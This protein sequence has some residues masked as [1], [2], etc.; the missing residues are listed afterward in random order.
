AV[1]TGASNDI[2][3]VTEIARNMVTKWGLS[4]R[5]GPISYD[6]EDNEPFLG[7]SMT[8]SGGIS[9]ETAHAIDEEMRSIIDACYERS[10]N[11]L[12]DNMAK[13]HL[14][15]DALMKY[16]T[17]DRKQIDEIMAGHEPGPPQSW[18]DDSDSSGSGGGTAADVGSKTTSDSD[19]E[20]GVPSPAHN[21][22]V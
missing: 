7:K 9:D 1:T 15:A 5:M 19:G 16:E 21:R 13:L 8:Q 11:V 18:N 4:D 10:K 22:S 17:I 2:E 20:D 3:R 6:N 14:M 12:E